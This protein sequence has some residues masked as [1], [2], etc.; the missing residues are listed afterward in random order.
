M[1]ESKQINTK[2]IIPLFDQKN[3]ANI[4]NFKEIHAAMV[5]HI[6]SAF[7]ETNLAHEEHK[8]QLSYAKSD[9]KNLRD[10]C[11]KLGPKQY[12]ET[13]LIQRQGYQLDLEEELVKEAEH[14]LQI[15]ELLFSQAEA[16]N[17]SP[18]ER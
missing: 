6:Q 9:L 4:S 14:I 3:E 7:F 13:L 18:D 11:N 1:N 17:A 8:K 2:G 10:Q 15:E 5:N 12:L 16:R